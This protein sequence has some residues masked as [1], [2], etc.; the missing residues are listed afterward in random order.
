ML[1]CVV[2]FDRLECLSPIS[3]LIPYH[4]HH[5]ELYILTS[6]V[7]ICPLIE[8]STDMDSATS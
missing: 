4:P 8:L 6:L 1:L 2:A 3:G 5:Q 7:V